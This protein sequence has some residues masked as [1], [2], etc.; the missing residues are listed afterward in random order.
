M[1][2]II[3]IAY[4]WLLSKFNKMLHALPSINT[5]QSD[6]LK[7][8]QML[9][10][11][12]FIKYIFLIIC[13]IVTGYQIYTSANQIADKTITS[14]LDTSYYSFPSNLLFTAQII[15]YTCVLYF[16]YIKSQHAGNK[17]GLSEVSVERSVVPSVPQVP[18]VPIQEATIPGTVIREIVVKFKDFELN[19]NTDT[20]PRTTVHDVVEGEKDDD[21]ASISASLSPMGET[22]ET[23][24]GTTQGTTVQI[25]TLGPMYYTDRDDL[26]TN[27]SSDMERFVTVP[28]TSSI[29]PRHKHSPYKLQQRYISSLERKK[30][31]EL[32]QKR[33]YVVSFDKPLKPVPEQPKDDSDSSGEPSPRLDS[34]LEASLSL[35]TVVSPKTQKKKVPIVHLQQPPKPK[36]ILKKTNEPLHVTDAPLYK[37]KGES[38]SDSS[39]GTRHKSSHRHHERKKY[40][41][42]SH[43]H[44]HSAPKGVDSY[45]IKAAAAAKMGNE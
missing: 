44:I 19:P 32:K 36:P 4:V 18:S 30:I 31:K 41:R 9:K 13:L 3:F 24:Q 29:V 27:S 37:V 8:R 34:T 1:E 26:S 7:L 16:S 43:S 21:P 12:I 40:H 20:L 15:L 25:A 35:S 45:F 38:E 39:E 5:A 42:H 2:W 17:P 23:T 22:Q 28:G 11:L 14:E 10:K 33:K 6:I